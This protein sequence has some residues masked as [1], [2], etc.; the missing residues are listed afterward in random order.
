MAMGSQR[1][2]ELMRKDGME[3]VESKRTK[4]EK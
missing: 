4:R 1:V 2:D 3:A